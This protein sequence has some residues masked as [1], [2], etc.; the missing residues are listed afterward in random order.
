MDPQ[1]RI[2]ALEAE[3]DGYKRDY[4]AAT[5]EA[6]KDKLIDLI[7]ESKKTLNILLQQ[8]QG[9]VIDFPVTLVQF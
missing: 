6:R 8:Q 1:L 7:T 9:K 4:A 5:P 2:D 3:I